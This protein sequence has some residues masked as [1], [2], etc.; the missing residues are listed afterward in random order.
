MTTETSIQ[1]ECP[2]CG[3]VCGFKPCYA[4]R[5]AR[6][7]NCN[8]RFVIPQRTG[9]PAVSCPTAAAEPLP[10]FYANALKG[11]LEAF[12]RLDSAIGL[13]F[14]A[15][16][17]VAHFLLGNVD[18][19]VTLPGFRLLM[20]I[21]WGVTF[22][23]FGGFSWYSME[24][25][26]AARLGLKPL[27]PV[28][29]GT[30]LEFLWLAVKS[31]YLFFVS[32]VV[33]LLPASIISAA[34]ESLGGEL[35]QFYYVIA[36]LCL[37]LWPMSLAI[38]ATELPVWR[39]FR[40]D[41]IVAAVAKTFVPYLFTAIITL[42]AFALIWLGIGTFATHEDMTLAAGLGWLALRLAGAMLFLFAMRT[43]GV[44]CL[45]YADVFPRLWVTPAPQTS[46]E[47]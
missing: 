39:I 5:T 42:T 9:L 17:V 3:R 40:Y 26:A 36:A 37:L 32:L 30:G 35:G 43:I 10:G 24:I 21:G 25:I 38:I 7:L 1:C 4:G 20:V 16:L 18:L 27:P 2:H 23:A 46:A 44:Y 12:S 8:T 11:G 13:V 28:E 31:C 33:A 34:V 45:H 41:L 14:C 19:S 15:A 6:C 22:I 29:P 47:A